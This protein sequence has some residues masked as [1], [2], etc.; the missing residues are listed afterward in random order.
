M[1]SNIIQ[2]FTL[3]IKSIFPGSDTRPTQVQDLDP[4]PVAWPNLSDLIGWGQ[5][6]SSTS[7]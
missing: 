5:K 2:D 1:D 6:I 4:W 7:W 3:F